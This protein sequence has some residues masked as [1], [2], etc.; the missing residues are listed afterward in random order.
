M[1]ETHA[2]P[3]YPAAQLFRQKTPGDWAGA[4]ERVSGVLQALTLPGASGQTT[5][6]LPMLEALAEE[7]SLH[8]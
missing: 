2:T 5:S 7:V 8:Q 3:W 1:Q 4:V 6:K